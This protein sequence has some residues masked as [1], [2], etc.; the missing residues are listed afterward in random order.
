M[1]AALSC[2]A[3]KGY[4]ATTIVDIERAAG[5]SV[6]SGGTYRH[7]TSKRE[8]LAEAIAA[9]SERRAAFMEPVNSSAT[10]TA[11]NAIELGRQNADLFRILFRDLLQFPDLRQQVIDGLVDGVYRIAAERAAEV[12]PNADAEAI[13]V[14]M[15]NATLGFTLL[16]SV[17]GVSPLGVDERRFADAWARLFELLIA[18]ELSDNDHKEKQNH[19]Q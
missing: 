14:V 19:E 3:A 7:F 18:D 9:L 12:V 2:F 13:A 6:G 17:L 5:L 8:M 4:E 10:G 1:D 16:E 15:C 11:H